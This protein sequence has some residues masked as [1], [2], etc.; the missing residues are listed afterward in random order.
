MK[1]K[2]AFTLAS[3]ASIAS[4]SAQGLYYVGQETTESIPLTWV[5]GASM[6]WDNNVTPLVTEG[7]PGHE[8]EVWSIN[9]YVQANFTNVDPQTT[10]NFYARAG[11]N[12]YLQEMD[13]PGTERTIPN[14][15]FGFDLNHS[16]SPR[17][18]FSSRNFLAYEMEPEFAV[19]ISNDRQLDPYFFYSSDNSVGYRWTQRVGSYT[20]FGFTGYLGDSFLADRKSWFVYH[21]MR[22]QLDQRTVLTAQYRY[23]QWTGDANDSSNHFITGGV[24]YRISQNSVFV[25]SAGVQLRSVDNGEDST[26]PFFEGSLRTQINSAFGVRAFAR[27]SMED[28]DTIQFIGANV[29]EYSDQQVLRIGITGDYRLTPRLTGFGG[30]DLVHTMYDGGNQVDGLGTA[31][32]DGRTEDLINAYIG[33]RARITDALNVDCS[34]NYTDSTSDFVNNDYD[35]LRLSAGVS[36]TF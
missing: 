1:K 24:E 6:I 33:L 16:V 7:N 35:R 8:D 9:P 19:G 26:S 30:V 25:G 34:I 11:V 2:T 17:L 18:R 4:L 32:D 12:Y 22:Y 15:R 10:I 21:Q 27:Y 3:I 5:A 13:A 20:G 14:L 29:F 28:F 23:S 36:Y 31:T